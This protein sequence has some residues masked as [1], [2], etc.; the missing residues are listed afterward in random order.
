LFDFFMLGCPG[1]D[2]GRPQSASSYPL[3]LNRP[4][5]DRRKQQTTGQLTYLP[6]ENPAWK[7][8]QP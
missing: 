4:K 6:A 5:L 7:T 8:S 2:Q 3:A 1:L